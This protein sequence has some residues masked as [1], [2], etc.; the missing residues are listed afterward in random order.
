M[1]NLPGP[2]E[3]EF[4]IVGYT[5][6][7][8]SHKLR[9]NIIVLGSPAPGTPVASITVQKRGG[10]TG[11]AQAIAD[12]MWGFLRLF[13]NNTL[14]AA[15]FTIWQYVAGTYAKN[16]ISSGI[17]ASPAGASAAATSLAHETVITMRSANGGILKTVVIE[18]IHTGSTQTALIPNSTGTPHQKWAAYLL[19]A[20]GVSISADDAY[21]VAGLRQSES[22]NERMFRKLYRGT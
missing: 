6:P 11:N 13:Y 12:Q 21:P 22:E 2:Y 5:S 18:G 16:F 8:R 20:D 19:S 9:Q 14:Q 17:P 1:P 15:S 7:V 4:E 10:G 3:I